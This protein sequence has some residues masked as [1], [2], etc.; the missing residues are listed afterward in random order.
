L[1]FISVNDLMAAANALLGMPGGNN[2]VVPGTLR[3]CEEFIKTALDRANNNQTFVQSRPCSVNML[4]GG[5]SS[6]LKG[7]GSGLDLEL[8][9]G[10]EIFRASPNPF[11]NTTR[12]D[13]VIGASEVGAIH[14]AVFD[15]AGRLV[16]TLVNGVQSPG[17]YSVDWN[18]RNDHGSV[19]MKGMYFVRGSVGGRTLST[20]VLFMP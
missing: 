2:T 4:A 15:V 20:R 19:M 9:T 16:H 8:E 14:I 5:I 3:R 6:N 13:Y 12:L 17:R 10:L 1:G 11:T 7:D 18:G